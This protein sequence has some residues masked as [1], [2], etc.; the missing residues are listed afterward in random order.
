MK[1]LLALFLILFIYF[2]SSFFNKKKPLV[3]EGFTH[4]SSLNKVQTPSDFPKESRVPGGLVKL[5]FKHKP[6]LFIGDEKL[7]VFSKKEKTDWLVLLP[8]SL[9]KGLEGIKLTSQTS[10]QYQ[11]HLIKLKEAG[12]LKQYINVKNREFVIA[13]KKTL[14][15]IKKESALKK[16]AFKRFSKIYN[17]DLKMIKPLDAILRH[18]FGRRRFFNGVSKNPHAGIDLSGKRGDKIRAPLGGEVIILGNLFYNGNLMLLDHGQGLITAYSHLSKFLKKDGE[19]V[20][21]GEFIAEVGSTGRATGPHLHWS[22]YLGGEPV[23]PELFLDFR[24]S[25]TLEVGKKP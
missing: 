23:N 14:K 6:E 17:D 13:S 5:R 11:L 2:T 19:W 20:R 8:L 7:Q 10:S 24:E 22:V 3:Q 9:Y 12:Y 16:E 1:F 4:K 15:R 18:D 21:Q 25:P